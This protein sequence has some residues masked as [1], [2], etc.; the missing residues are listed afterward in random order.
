MDSIALCLCEKSHSSNEIIP[1]IRSKSECEE[2]KYGLNSFLLR[3]NVVFLFFYMSHVFIG[4]DTPAMVAKMLGHA[5]AEKLLLVW[6]LS[7][8]LSSSHTLILLLLLL[9]ELGENTSIY[10]DSE[11]VD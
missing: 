2:Y 9:L 1:L 6:V 5:E 8:F 4:G 10:C 7:F 3:V 11:M